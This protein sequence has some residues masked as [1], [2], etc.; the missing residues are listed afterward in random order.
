MLDTRGKICWDQKLEIKNED[1][2]SHQGQNFN[3]QMGCLSL[4]DRT[5]H[6]NPMKIYMRYSTHEIFRGISIYVNVCKC[7]FS[8]IRSKSWKKTKEREK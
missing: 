7:S 3:K 8:F 2:S 4:P 6:R 5:K 1:A